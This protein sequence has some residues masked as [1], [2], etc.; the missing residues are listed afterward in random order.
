[1]IEENWKQKYE[2]LARAV[3]NLYYS[4]HWR[5]DREVDSKT[6]WESVRDA[7]GLKPG[8]TARRLTPVAV[9][10]KIWTPVAVHKKSG[11]SMSLLFAVV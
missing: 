10:K 8:D 11:K 6:L 7:A 1:V 9:H 4:A 2:D 5:P 3:E